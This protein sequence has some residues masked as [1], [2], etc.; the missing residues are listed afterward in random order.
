[1]KNLGWIFTILLAIFVIW[2]RIP[3]LTKNISS[4]GQTFP[5]L[6]LTRLDGSLAPLPNLSSEAAVVLFWTRTCGPCKFEMERIQASITQGKIPA[7]RVVAVHIG[8]VA[9][10]VE[11]HMRTFGFTFRTLMDVDGIAASTIGVTMTPTIYLVSKTR[12]VA[13]ASSG[14]GPTDIWRIERY[15]KNN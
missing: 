10:E 4:E 9:S 13:W 3:E 5:Q 2:R 14:I 6:N 15:L 11:L 7:D 1:M 12:N 8:G